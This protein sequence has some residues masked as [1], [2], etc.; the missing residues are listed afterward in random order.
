M[1]ATKPAPYEAVTPHLRIVVNRPS[2][3]LGLESRLATFAAAHSVL[4]LR[5]SLAA[6]FCGFGLLKLFPGASPAEHLASETLKSLTLGL[7]KPSVSLPLLGVFEIAVG[8]GLL[9]FPRA[10]FTIPALLGHLI[11]TL[12]PL[13]LFSNETFSYFPIPTLAGQY[14]LKNVV[15]VAAAIAILGSSSPRSSQ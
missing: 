7:L 6:V 10:R 5:L 9:F 15:L 12:A 14:I 1:L 4:L 8:L 3:S 2:Q 11:G 13:V